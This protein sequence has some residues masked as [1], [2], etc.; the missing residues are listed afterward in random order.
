MANTYA[1]CRGEDRTRVK[2]DHRLG[3]ESATGVA[4]T[5]VTFATAHVRKDG[6]GYIR[7]SRQANY[8]APIPDNAKLDVIVMFG[9]ES[10]P[11]AA[12]VIEPR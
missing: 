6:S 4:Q 9:A 8:G 12:G 10:G 7:V 1:G 2:E 3:S 11:D 5:Y